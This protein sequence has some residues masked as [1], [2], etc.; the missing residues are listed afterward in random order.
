MYI[1]IFSFSNQCWVSVKFA[2]AD[3]WV[4]PQMKVIDGT[5]AV[6]IVLDEINL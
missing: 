4:K 2:I 1:I 3:N 5:K 6:T